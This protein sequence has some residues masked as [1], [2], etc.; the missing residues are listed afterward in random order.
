LTTWLGK[1]GDEKS[2]S[3]NVVRKTGDKRSDCSLLDS[4]Q[5]FV[6]LIMCFT[7]HSSC[8]GRS[9]IR[10]SKEIALKM[11]TVIFAK[12]ENLQ[13]PTQLIPENQSYTINSSHKN[14]RTRTQALHS[15]F[16]FPWQ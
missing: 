6:H 8:T 3:D 7:T 15:Q 13:H 9:I 12:M 11:A 5:S 14:L 10:P 4:T 16:Q 2:F 1:R